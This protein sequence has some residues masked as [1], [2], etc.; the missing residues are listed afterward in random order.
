MFVCLKV[1]LN[2]RTDFDN[3]GIEEV[4]AFKKDFFY[5]FAADNRTLYNSETKLKVMIW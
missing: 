3:F 2:P 4:G 5:F 1:L